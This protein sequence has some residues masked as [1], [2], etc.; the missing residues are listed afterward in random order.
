MNF[1][2][3]K[4]FRQQLLGLQLRQQSLLGQAAMGRGGEV[5]N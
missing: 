3:A 1:S 2:C 4:A 5:F